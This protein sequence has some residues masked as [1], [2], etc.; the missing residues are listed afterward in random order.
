MAIQFRTSFLAAWWF[1]QTVRRAARTI[2]PALL[3]SS[4][5]LS[6][7]PPPAQLFGPGGSTINPTGS[8]GKPEYLDSLGG[9]PDL[10]LPIRGITLP[11]THRDLTPG[12]LVNTSTGNLYLSFTDVAYPG[13]GLP[14]RF[15]RSYNAQDS[16][17]GPLGAGWTHSYNIFLT[18][19]AFGNVTV[20]ESDGHEVIFDLESGIYLAATP[21]DFDSLQQT[22]SAFVLTRH[23]QVR[24]IFTLSGQLIQIVDRN[25]NHQDFS[26]SPA[27]CLISITDT[28]GRVF[29]LSYD[30]NNH[31]T[32]LTDPAGRVFTYQYISGELVG[33]KDQTLG[34]TSFGYSGGLL[35][36]LVSP[37]SIQVL[38]VSY[39]SSSRVTQWNDG[40]GLPINFTYNAPPA[41]TI[42]VDRRGNTTQHSYDAN[43][44]LVQVT[45]ALG[46]LTKTTY[47]SNNERLSVTNPL[48]NT[49][50]YGYD[51]SGNMTSI[52][53]A[54]GNVTQY[55]YNATNDKLT[56]KVPLG[57]VTTYV[58][59]ANGNRLSSKD[60]LGDTTRFAY[61]TQGEVISTTDANGHLTG[62]TYDG[63]GNLTA[64]KDP[65]G[66]VT[67]Y[68]YN[69]AGDQVSVTDAK[70]NVTNYVYDN[71][72]R[73]TS[74]TDPLSNV[75]Q[76]SYDGD[77]DLISTLEPTGTTIGYTYDNTERLVN[78]SAPSFSV[79][80]I[81]DGNGN[82]IS[83][84]DNGGHTTAYVYDALNRVTSITQPSFVP[85]P[86][87]PSPPRTVFYAYDAAGNRIMLTYPDGK[88]IQYAYDADNHLIQVTDF[89]SNVTTYGYDKDGNR[90]STSYPN[91]ASQATLFDAAGRTVTIR[92]ITK[93]GS[94]LLATIFKYILDPAGNVLRSTDALGAVN[95]FTYDAANEL[96]SAQTSAG[97]TTY[98]YD[99]TGNRTTITAPG[100][101]VTG[102]AYNADN[103]LVS[104]TTSIFEEDFTYDANGN[105]I[106]SAGKSALVY[107]Y[108]ARNRLIGVSD[109]ETGFNENFSYDGD[110]NRVAE[111]MAAGAIEWVNDLS[112]S[113]LV[114]ELQQLD[115]TGSISYVRGADLISEYNSNSGVTSFFHQDVL[116]SI[117]GLSNSAGMLVAQSVYDPWGQGVGV[118]AEFQFTGESIDPG[119][120]LYYLRARYYDPQD[121]IFIAPDPLPGSNQTPASKNHYTYALNNPLRFTDHTGLRGSAAPIFCSD[122]TVLF[123]ASTYADCPL[124]AFPGDP[125]LTTGR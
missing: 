1:P 46:G 70:G 64:V 28:S 54:L 83:M 53:D 109:D 102:F 7:A 52:T 9:A 98:A 39:D 90:I 49:T 20:K 59:D 22:P 18:Q 42:I 113:P 58:Y 78:I 101:N 71:L 34:S 47:D 84:T 40:N 125:G 100:S 38:Q 32:S 35:T 73:L 50:S 63:N 103:Q 87:P 112:S 81:Y 57:Y 116:G 19:D 61:N 17:S 89:S 13:V 68:A 88:T 104:V 75:T 69:A 79:T 123:P 99:A 120:G 56:S 5:L 124:P 93:T 3:V 44:Q 108:D 23:N 51:G 55:T 85:V 92:N 119:T 14:F 21:G 37:R 95:T 24:F 29:S 8:I 6:A 27:G 41:A 114:L 94:G 30:V 62:F 2:A 43:L 122:G 48:G 65:L 67:N 77:S 86:N 91:G 33:T 26:Y 97:A 45:D 76:Y 118:G 25:G 15:I 115:P 11:K 36:T 80:S 110:G 16:Y 66:N 4:V 74:A 60:P 117:V 105:R 107:T 10:T 31:L 72:D 12:T 111:T 106:T 121:G 82:R 96:I